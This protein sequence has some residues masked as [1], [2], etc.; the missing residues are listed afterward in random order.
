MLLKAST[1]NTFQHWL[2]FI[3]NTFQHWLPVLGFETRKF[4]D[5]IQIGGMLVLEATKYDIVDNK[6]TNNKRTAIY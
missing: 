5:L 2:P 3:C 1:C 4:S 6:Q